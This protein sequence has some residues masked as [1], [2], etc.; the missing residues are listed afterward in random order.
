MGFGKKDRQRLTLPGFTLVPSARVVLT[1]LFGMGRGDPHRYSHLNVFGVSMRC[2][3]HRPDRYRDHLNVF[4]V[5][6][7]S[8]PH[9]PDRYRDHFN[10]LSLEFL[11]LGTYYYGLSTINYGLF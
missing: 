2:Y 11:V 5:S 3:P 9:R 4:G 1:A 7:R 6:I 10:A 8:Y